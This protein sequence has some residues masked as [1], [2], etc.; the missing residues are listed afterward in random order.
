MEWCGRKGVLFACSR[1]KKNY[2]GHWEQGGNWLQGQTRQ[3]ENRRFFRKQT[4]GGGKKIPARKEVVEPERK[5]SSNRSEV[6][7]GE[8]EVRSGNGA[9]QGT[10]LDPLKKNRQGSVEDSDESIRTKLNQLM[11]RCLYA[12]GKR[13]NHTDHSKDSASVKKGQHRIPCINQKEVK[14]NQ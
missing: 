2:K 13:E 8:S 7:C 5:G 1:E 11:L 14:T 6:S 3:R 9:D 10:G 12:K 4:S